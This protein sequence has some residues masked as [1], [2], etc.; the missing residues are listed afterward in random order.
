MKRYQPI[1][2]AAKKADKNESDTVTIVTD[3]LEAIF[4]YDNVS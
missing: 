4:G 3:L 2:E 1:I